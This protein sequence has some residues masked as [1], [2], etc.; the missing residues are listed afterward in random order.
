MCIKY[1]KKALNL[2]KHHGIETWRRLGL[3]SCNGKIVH[4]NN[5]GK[6]LWDKVKKSSKMGQDKKT[7]MSDSA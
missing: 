4:T 1:S 3:V 5:P 7:L 6:S 2:Q